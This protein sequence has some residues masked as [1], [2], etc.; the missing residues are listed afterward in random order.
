[1]NDPQGNEY[2]AGDKVGFIGK[3]QFNSR[4]RAM[5]IGVVIHLTPKML[6]V[7]YQTQFNKYELEYIHP[8]RAIILERNVVI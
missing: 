6:V 4:H 2:K 8:D 3:K 7:S 5:Q 1:M